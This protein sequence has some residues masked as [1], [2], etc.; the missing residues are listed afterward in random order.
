MPPPCSCF[1]ENGVRA[2]EGAVSIITLVTTGK[3]LDPRNCN[4]EE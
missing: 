1:G 3:H 2:I 4:K